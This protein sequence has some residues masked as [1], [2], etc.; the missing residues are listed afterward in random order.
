MFGQDFVLRQTVNP[1]FVSTPNP[2]NYLPPYFPKRWLNLYNFKNAPIA[3][4]TMTLTATRF[5]NSG[6]RPAR[7][8]SN[9]SHVLSTGAFMPQQ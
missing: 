5:A 3:M 7:D 4:A 8:R 9:L 2:G 1:G 6:V